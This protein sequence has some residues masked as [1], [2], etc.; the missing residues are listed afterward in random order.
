[1]HFLSFRHVCLLERILHKEAPPDTSPVIIIGMVYLDREPPGIAVTLFIEDVSKRNHFW[2]MQMS[3]SLPHEASIVCYRC[4]L[5]EAH[6]QWR[7]MPHCFVQA[8]WVVLTG[9]HACFPLI[10]L[11]ATNHRYENGSLPL[12]LCQRLCPAYRVLDDELCPHAGGPCVLD[13]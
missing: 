4:A 3:I 11:P 1:M 12:D 9:M 6:W 13:C 7:F 10:C 8:R 5:K 2:H